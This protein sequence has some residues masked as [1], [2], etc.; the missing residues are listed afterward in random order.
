M[1]SDKRSPKHLEE[2]INAVLQAEQDAEEA[3][4]QCDRDAVAMLES[5]RETERRIMNRADL[6]I[7]DLHRRR[8]DLVEHYLSEIAHK[9][10]KVSSLS[11]VTD[12][13]LQCISDAVAAMADELLGASE[14]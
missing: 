10:R 9:E 11:I 3:L 12:L 4:N 8:N 6:R 5:A 2:A 7:R 13:D 1:P 14:E